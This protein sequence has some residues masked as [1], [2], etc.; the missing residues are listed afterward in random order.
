MEYYDTIVDFMGRKIGPKG[1]QFYWQNL[2][3]AILIF[4]YRSA[5]VAVVEPVV[6]A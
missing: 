1:L 5:T 4:R 3:Y 2:L 6:T